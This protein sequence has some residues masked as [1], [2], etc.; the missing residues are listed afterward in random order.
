MRTMQDWLDSYSGDH[1]NPTNRL[2]HWFCVPPIVWSVIALLWAI[3]VPASLFRPGTVAVAVM[4]LAF[5]WYWKH[6]H[7]LALALLIAF[8][9]LGLLTNLLYY[10]LGAA[11]LCYLAIGVFVVAWIGQFIGHQ[12][13]GRRP[14]FLT[15]LSYLLIGPAWLMA[16]LLRGLG[17]KQVT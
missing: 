5:Y 13:E 1:Q 11:S 7:R 14:S 17:F 10:R 4:V 8:A 6:S 16:K 15:D 2:F 12:F 3:P 9:L